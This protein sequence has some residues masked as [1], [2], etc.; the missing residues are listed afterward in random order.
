M[1]PNIIWRPSPKQAEFLACPDDETL[2]GGAAGGGKSD[3]LLIDALG[4][5]QNAI[6]N[7]VYRAILFRRSFPELGDLIDRSMYIYPKIVPGCAYKTAEHEW[8]FPEGAKVIFGYA[9]A[10]KDRYRYQGRQYQ[11]IGFDEITH[12]PTPVVY[13]FLFSRLRTP[14]P[15]LKCYM[16]AATNPGG[17]GHKWVRERWRIDDQGNPT[18]FVI[19]VEG[20]QHTRR[21]IPAKLQDNPHLAESGYRQ[22]LLQLD[23][24]SR[25]ALL[26]GRWD[27]IEVPG[28]WY[29][30]ELRDAHNDGRIGSV[31]FDPKLPVD[32]FW[33]LGIGD[34]TSIWFVQ[35]TAFEYRF[36]DYYEMSGEALNH[37]ALVLQKKANELKY[38]Y[39][40]HHAPHDIEVRELGTGKTRL[41]VA[42]TLGINFK[43]VPKLSF[44]D[45]IHAARMAF[46]RSWFD[47]GKCTHGLDA[48]QN[49]RKD[50]H[51]KTG[52]WSPKPVHD[53]ASH[54]AD[55]Y[56]YAAISLQDEGSER[57]KPDRYKPRRRHSF[58]GA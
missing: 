22:R 9:E 18:Q 57:E 10:D 19:D 55:A 24:M 1:E 29:K 35:R 47:Q 37:Y 21:F 28:A 36:I 26:D 3:A 54:A 52:E 5:Q 32:T 40:T 12:W 13:E 4:L 2:Y 43:I 25:A 44:E 8:V 30:A 20:T 56:R 23:E 41:E 11:W 48:L 33:D 14:D 45:G 53:W 34:S 27:I 17:P 51:Q 16:R 6:L 31:P 50:V 38:V 15:A 58:M 46:G 39:G 42:R 7:P 49:Y